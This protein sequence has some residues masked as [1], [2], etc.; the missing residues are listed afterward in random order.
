MAIPFPKENQ[1]GWTVKKGFDLT[2]SGA[3][4]IIRFELCG[5]N[6]SDIYL[7]LV[8]FVT[9]QVSTN[10]IAYYSIEYRSLK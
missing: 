2:T 6:K 8:F 1:A 10:F 7:I 9:M 5:N 4:G 3:I